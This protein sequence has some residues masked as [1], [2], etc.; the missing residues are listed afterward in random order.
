M[1]YLLY[2]IF[3]ILPSIIW[4]LFYLRKDSHPESNWMVLKIFFYGMLAAAVAAF[5]EIGVF[6]VFNGLGQRNVLTLAL[7]T[8]L[9]VALTE[10][11]LKYL[12]IHLTTLRSP[13]LDEPLDVALY[14]IIAA[15]GF[16]GLENIIILFYADLG[17]YLLETA[18]F[19]AF[20]FISATF[21]HALCSGLVGYFAARSFLK[22]KKRLWYL[23][24]GLLIATLLHGAYN[25]SIIFIRG[26]QRFILPVIILVLLAFYLSW[27]LKKL[28]RLKS[29]CLIK[30]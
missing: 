14:M 4:L 24:L 1:P 25:F 30:S 16:A 13:E 28:K 11:L 7:N 27:D 19:S 9:G 29:I 3:G 2:I 6:K 26:G 22:T 12:V 15:L 18:A 21:L 8:F 23:A 10:E 17:G 5:L 20:R